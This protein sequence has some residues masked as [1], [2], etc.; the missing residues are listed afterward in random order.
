MILGVLVIQ[1]VLTPLLFYGILHFIER[2]LQSQFIDQ[3]RN[4]T[5]LYA[6]LIASAVVEEDIPH[7]A[8]ILSEA[9][10]NED[11]VLARFINPEGIVIRPDADERSVVLNFKEDFEFDEHDDHVYFIAMQVLNE[12]D[13]EFLGTMKL[14]YDEMPTQNRI[15][16]AY[17]YG[18]LLAAGYALLSILIVIFY[19]RR[20]IRPISQ[21]QSMARSIANGDTAAGLNVSTDILEISSL[22]NDLDSMRQTL[23]DQHR[24]VKDR[25]KR[26]YAILDN[27]GEGIISI[28]V[29]GVIGSFN[30]A[31]ESIFGY[32][33][34][35]VLGRNV[36]VLIPLPDR[37]HLDSHIKN[38]LATGEAKIIGVGQRL[39]AQHKDGHLIP[40]DLT[41]TK[42][43]LRQEYTFIGIVRDLTKEEE[44]EKQ[45]LQIWR[46]VEQSPVSI[47]ITD[48]NGM[49]EYV[50]PHFCQVTGYRLEE[51]FGA[52]PRI[53]KSGNTH[54]DTYRELWATISNGDIWRGVFQNRKRSGEL[55]WESATICPVQDQNNE[56]THYIALKEDI[57]EHR[58]KDR[59]LTQ[60]MKMEV[61][62][63]MTDGIAHDFNN[64]LTIILGNL[65]ILMEDVSRNADDEK[66]SPI[67]DAMSAAYDGTNLIK[68]LLIFSRREEPDSRPMEIG[69]FMEELHHL[70]NRTIP[71]DIVVRLEVTKDTGTV[72]IDANRLESAVLNL[73]INARDAMP[74]GGELLISIDKAIL[75]ESEEVEGGNL[76][77][78]NY[79]FIR[80]ADNGT[81]MTE[82]IRQQA[83]EPFFTTK[84]SGSGTGLGLS[85]VHDLITQSGGGIRIESEPDKG[86]TITLILPLY[87]QAADLSIKEPEVLTQLPRGKET[88]LLVEDREKVR[89]FANRILSHLGY[90]L[91]EAENA[92]KA[93]EYLQSNN[94][95]DLLFTDIV[96]PGDMDGRDL[97]RYASSLKS[98][99]KILLTTGME[100]RAERGS[101]FHL[102]FPLLRKPYSAEQLAQ[103]I[104]SVL[105]TGQLTG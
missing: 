16:V 87:E 19:G 26:L 100:S 48:V 93:L 51:V 79:I 102:N 103:S 73:V 83:L 28:D 1:I 36:S 44:K 17:R 105:N 14:G 92:A 63:R 46:A 66:M 86:T 39:Q 29:K 81:G 90:N 7:Q 88:I 41:V 50:N 27:A 76:A 24:D 4:N 37:K 77:A 6:T 82:D 101:D 95:V 22:T 18:S 32:T 67:A 85:M 97:A 34:M 74:D 52:N 2:S 75:L 23:V 65:Q 25:E 58:E 59:M 94:E 49:I 64:L 89:R 45:L 84:T 53:L 54:S 15:D 21:L 91:I 72:L 57:T 62:G 69:T 9:L 98:T 60:A 35:Q 33:A 3:V 68:Q 30:R 38:Y 78:G 12:I 56:I 42:I 43:R 71:E 20:L 55:F 40:V 99:L 61:I 13:G 31:A 80:I 104:R 11:L 70:L 47:I 8:A 5:H 96:M 10:I